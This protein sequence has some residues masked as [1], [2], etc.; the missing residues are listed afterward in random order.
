LGSCSD[1]D[2]HRRSFHFGS[3]SSAQQ[4]GFGQSTTMFGYMDYHQ[5]M[6]SQLPFQVPTTFTAFASQEN[7]FSAPP[8]MFETSTMTPPSAFCGLSPMHYY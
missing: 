5:S 6:S 1:A 4:H 2:P 7:M 8:N 3:Y